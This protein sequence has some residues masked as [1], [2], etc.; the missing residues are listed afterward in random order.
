MLTFFVFCCN[1]LTCFAFS[2]CVCFCV[3]V[4]SKRFNIFRI[5]RLFLL[6]FFVSNTIVLACF[7]FCVCD[8]VFVYTNKRL[9]LFSLLINKI[10]ECS[11][12]LVLLLSLCSIKNVLAFVFVSLFNEY[13]FYF[14][15]LCAFSCLP[16]KIFSTFFVF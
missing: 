6:L 1:V 13:V 12:F 11:S 10:P 2:V 3:S 4:R 7:V 9:N 8:C 16:V 15:L 5:L 14:R